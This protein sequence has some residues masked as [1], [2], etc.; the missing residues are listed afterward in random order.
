VEINDVYTDSEVTYVSSPQC[1][2]L[3]HHSVCD[4]ASSRADTEGYRLLESTTIVPLLFPNWERVKSKCDS[5]AIARWS[6]V[7][8]LESD[9]SVSTERP[10]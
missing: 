7:P 2:Q 9:I 6:N 4:D 3:P 1:H 5:E 10:C 8:V